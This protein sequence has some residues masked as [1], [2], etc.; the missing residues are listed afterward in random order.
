MKKFDK[1]LPCKICGKKPSIRQERYLAGVEH[2]CKGG[3]EYMD[4]WCEKKYAIKGWNKK[5]EM[6]RGRED[7]KKD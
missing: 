7:E 6:E 4:I 2:I 1:I 5:Q 3:K